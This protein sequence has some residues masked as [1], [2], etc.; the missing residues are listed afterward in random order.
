MDGRVADPRWVA[1]P[2]HVDSECRAK[3]EAALVAAASPAR[4]AGRQL[5]SKVLARATSIVLPVVLGPVALPAD[6]GWPGVSVSLGVTYLAG[7]AAAEEVRLVPTVLR[8]GG[9]MA[10]AE[11]KVRLS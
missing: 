10:Y 3:L 8:R 5:A 2:L 11:C 9:S 4:A 7:C 6:G 1:G